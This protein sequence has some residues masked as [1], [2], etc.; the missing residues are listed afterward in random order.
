MPVSDV[1]FQ[2]K[3]MQAFIC[4]MSIDTSVSVTKVLRKASGLVQLV[5]S[6]CV[7]GR[8]D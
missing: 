8:G 5:E 6:G 1:C 4:I 7:Q 2:G 3:S